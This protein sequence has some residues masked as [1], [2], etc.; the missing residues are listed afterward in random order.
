MLSLGT[1][2]KGIDFS[3]LPPLQVVLQQQQAQG[4]LEHY[5]FRCISELELPQQK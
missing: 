2:G 3:A 4:R 5:A 1:G